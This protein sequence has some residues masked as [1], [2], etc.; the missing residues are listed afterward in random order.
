M[1]GF[2]Q[3]TPL[4]HGPG[5][6]Y[7]KSGWWE[8]LAE[9][10]ERALRRKL[11]KTTTVKYWPIAPPLK[12]RA[13]TPLRLLSTQLF[14]SQVSA[15]SPSLGPYMASRRHTL[16]PSTSQRSRRNS[17]DVAVRASTV[18]PPDSTTAALYHEVVFA[19]RCSRVHDSAVS[20]HS[21]SAGSDRPPGSVGVM[22]RHFGASR[23]LQ[24]VREYLVG[25][26]AASVYLFLLAC[27]Q[28]Y[29]KPRTTASGRGV[30][31]GDRQVRP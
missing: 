21:K 14:V 13:S 9:N 22:T 29:R 17:H 15:R 31:T 2:V 5:Y 30:Q 19:V 3:K 1:A 26:F 20:S 27:H 23:P 25:V 12:I 8:A 10:I 6:F 11:F 28:A 24:S 7:C 18:T 4:K 16:V